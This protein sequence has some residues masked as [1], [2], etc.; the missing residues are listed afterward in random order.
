[1]CS[2]AHCRAEPTTSAYTPYS[3]GLSRRSGACTPDA[4]RRH[5]QSQPA[6][7]VQPV[8]A[9]PFVGC[10]EA[11]RRSLRP[12]SAAPAAV[13]DGIPAA[14]ARRRHAPAV[15]GIAQEFR[16]RRAGRFF[17][18]RL[19]GFEPGAGRRVGRRVVGG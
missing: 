16:A 8:Q 5:D 12:A 19:G 15:T 3:C 1:M 14:A 17:R 2:E 18:R 13:E 6:G 11:Q 9:Q 10:G 4:G 7:A